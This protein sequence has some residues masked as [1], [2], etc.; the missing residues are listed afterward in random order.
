MLFVEWLLDIE[1]YSSQESLTDVEI[2]INVEG[3]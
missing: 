3:K 1:G 2:L